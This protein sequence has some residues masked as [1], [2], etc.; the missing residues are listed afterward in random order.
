MTFFNKKED[1]LELQLTPYGRKLLSHGKLKPEFYA[2]F[3]DD[4]LYDTGK[5][6]FDE[7]NSESKARILTETPSLKPQSTNFGVETN[8]DTMYGQVIDNYMPNPIGSNSTIEKKTSG[9]NMVALD[10]EMDTFSLSSSLNSPILNIPQVNCAL[11]FTM[12]VDNFNTFRGNFEDLANE[13]E[14]RT[15]DKGNFIKLEKETL[16]FYLTERNGFVNTDAYEVEVF[17]YEEDESDLKK[18]NF[19]KKEDNVKND[20]L[21]IP[22]EQIIET[23]P[24]NVEYYFEFLLDSEIPD[25]EI[26]KGLSKLKESNIYL[27]LDLKCPDRQLSD[28]DIY[29]ST[30]GDVEECD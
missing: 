23:T 30:I 29:N 13:F 20:L 26:C 7:V 2:F 15:D 11:N 4:I 24:D 5:A 22:K 28:V 19:L 12:S 17:M 21:H 6:G 16:V 10:K 1:V 9:W 25:E 3:D 27:E 14:L 8:I 18:L